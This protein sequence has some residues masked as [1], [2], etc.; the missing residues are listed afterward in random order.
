M[1]AENVCVCAAP[2][3]AVG[4]IR[5]T[6]TTGVRVTIAVADL[7]GSAWLVAFTVTVCPDETDGGA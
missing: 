4:G 6:A 2:R 5:L 3:V 1:D 7:D